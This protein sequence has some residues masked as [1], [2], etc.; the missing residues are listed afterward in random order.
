GPAVWRPSHVEA[1]L[2]DVAVEHLVV[3][4]LDAE[5]TGVL[6]CLPRPEP[7]ELVPTDHLRPDEAALQVGMDDP[8]ALGRPGAGAER[9][10]PR[11]LVAGREE[12]APAEEVMGG[13]GHAGE[14]AL[15]E[16]EPL[17]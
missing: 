6:G 15:A 2:E 3:L 12:R 9:P 5:P 8:S 4:A 17:E 10:R 14:R 7:E 11:L 13:P 1:D 16:S